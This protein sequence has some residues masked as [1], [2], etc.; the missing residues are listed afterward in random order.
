MKLSKRLA[1]LAVPALL[2]LG[3]PAQA[4]T[5][6]KIGYTSPEILLANMPEAKQVEQQLGTHAKKLQEQGN[7][8]V[9]YYQTKV[10]EYQANKQKGMTPEADEAATRELQKLEEEIRAFQEEGRG[11]LQNK[12]QELLAPLLDRIRKAIEEEA[13][14]GGYTYILNVGGGQ[15]ASNILYGPPT[16]DITEKVLK[17]MGITLPAEGAAANAPAP[18]ASAPKPAPAGGAKPATGGKKN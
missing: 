15:G 16:D 14:A 7:V 9:N 12:Q 10:G 4:Q 17:R 13:Q 8:K 18:A 5:P 1:I 3:V 2:A 6:F 11:G